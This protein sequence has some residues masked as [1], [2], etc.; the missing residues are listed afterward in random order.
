M[1]PY[2]NLSFEEIE[3]KEWASN[4]VETILKDITP[5]SFQSVEFCR[6][7]EKPQEL[8]TMINEE[9]PKKNEYNNPVRRSFSFLESNLFFTPNDERVRQ[10]NTRRSQS[11]MLPSTSSNIQETC[12]EPTI[13]STSFSSRICDA[14]HNTDRA[15]NI[16]TE[17]FNSHKKSS[18]ELK[19]IHVWKTTLDQYM[20]QTPPSLDIE[21]K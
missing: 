15:S 4:T 10:K 16:R 14:W 6:Q 1:P 9:Y 12:N 7:T 11:T 3:V 20:A 17:L 18:K 19:A 8:Q 5:V 13:Y 21:V 2:T